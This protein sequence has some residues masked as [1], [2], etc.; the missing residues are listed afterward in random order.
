[1][2]EIGIIGQIYEDR[3]TKKQGKLVE[4]DNKFKTLLMESEDG[5]S[6][7][8]TFGGFKSNWRKVD[9]PEQTIEEA[10]QEEVPE[11]QITVETPVK[12][13]VQP[14]VVKERKKQAPRNVNSVLEKTLLDILDYAKSFNSEKVST[15][16]APKKHNITLKVGNRRIF[17]LTYM[18]RN[19]VFM[20]CVGKN[21]FL[22]VKDNAYVTSAKFNESWHSMQYSFI[23]ECTELK[24]F[25]SDAREY[26]VEYL[27]GDIEEE[28]K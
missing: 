15:G 22:R 17:I 11:E 2:S 23:I 10:M 26:I 7:N 12:K 28:D 25:L 8:I 14:K 5:K 6:F 16:F 1:M 20:V 21:F 9:E 4:R 3:R 24:T 27:S 18:I 19:G 13:S